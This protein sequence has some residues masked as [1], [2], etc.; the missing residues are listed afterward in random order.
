MREQRIQPGRVACS[1]D[2]RWLAFRGDDQQIVIHDSQTLA[3]VDSL[4]V[5][6]CFEPLLT[7][8]PGYLAWNDD[9]HV[10]IAAWRDARPVVVGTLPLAGRLPVDIAL[11]KDGKSLAII[12]AGSSLV[13]QFE[14][15]TGRRTSHACPDDFLPRR[16]RFSSTEQGLLVA[17]EQGQLWVSDTRTGQHSVWDAHAGEV[18]AIAA[19]P[20][21]WIS[22]GTDGFIRLWDPI[23]NAERLE[24]SCPT[25]G[26]ITLLSST[27]NGLSLVDQ[28]GRLHDLRIPEGR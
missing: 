18:T 16:V 10:R 21:L 5:D 26:P 11:S 27:A 1:G 28:E 7:A 13:E 12:A 17:S 20:D 14:W 25:R 9:T 24:I 22:A 19:G 2:G 8:V 6:D 3:V 4:P 23:S 15:Q